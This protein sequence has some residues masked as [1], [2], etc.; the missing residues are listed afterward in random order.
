MTA[1]PSLSVCCMT[2]DPPAQAATALR[3]LRDVADEIVV[4]VDSRVEPASLAAY[5]DVADRVVRFR[6]RPPVDRPRAWLAA[7]C[8]GD[9]VLSLD[10]DEVPSQALLRAL[11]ELVAATDVVQ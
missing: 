9:W 11:P 5:D 4:A 6:F 10:G 3:A 7:Q 1:M 8:H 2:A